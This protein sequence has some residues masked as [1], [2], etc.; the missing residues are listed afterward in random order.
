MRLELGLGRVGGNGTVGHMY[1][2]GL[3]PRYT[4][5]TLGVEFLRKTGP[6]C[7]WGPRFMLDSAPTTE[8]FILESSCC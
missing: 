7:H 4:M 1:M 5:F 8:L 3:D 6:E 2:S